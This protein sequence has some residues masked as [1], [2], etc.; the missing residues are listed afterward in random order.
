MVNIWAM[1]HDEEFWGDPWSFRPERFLE[2]NGQLLPLDHPNRTHLMALG[3]GT[4]YCMGEV[5]AWRRL[6]LY[7]AYIAQ[8]FNLWPSES[9]L[10]SCDCR[11]FPTS[12]I[13]EPTTF[14]VKLLERIPNSQ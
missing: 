13:I 9:G 14:H 11:T 3:S 7:T 12:L 2:E 10:T 6:F 8:S 5:F 4:R 1:H